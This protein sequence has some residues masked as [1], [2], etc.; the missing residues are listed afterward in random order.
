MTILTDQRPSYDELARRLAELEAKAKSKA[1]LRVSD[2]GKKLIFHHGHGRFP[3][4]LYREQWE[5]LLA[6][7]SEIAEA[8]KALP[9]KE[10]K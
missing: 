5:S 8:I 9:R 6:H 2:D 3:V 7:A 1:G 10:S 4:T